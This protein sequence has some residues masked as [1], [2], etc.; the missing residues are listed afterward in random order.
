MKKINNK[1]KIILGISILSINNI[2]AFS[3]DNLLSDSKSESEQ[4]NIKNIQNPSSETIVLKPLDLV[5][6]KIQ[7]KSI[8][9]TNELNLKNNH[10]NI[11]KEIEKE[12]IIYQEYT[13]KVIESRNSKIKLLTKEKEIQ[14]KELE[15]SKIKIKELIKNEKL[16][17]SKLQKTEN[18]NNQ[19]EN[20]R[21]INN[22]TLNREEALE[23]L[24]KVKEKRKKLKIR[25]PMILN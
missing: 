15:D 23:L 22:K 8:N 21:L 24:E 13:E 11:I 5:P 6:S 20:K 12:Y 4:K 18:I 9:T 25:Y 10:I 14:N 19:L 3:L 2:Y 17:A 1:I 7:N 16:I